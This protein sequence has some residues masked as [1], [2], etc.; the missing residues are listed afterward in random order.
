MTSSKYA[1]RVAAG[2]DP[3]RR[4]RI[5]AGGLAGVS[6]E[7]MYLLVSL[8]AVVWFYIWIRLAIR[9]G[10]IGFDFEGTLWNAGAAILDGRSPYPAPVIAEVDAGNP[11][12][13]P[14][15]LMVLV[16]PLT[17][18]PWWVGVTVWTALLGAALALALYVLDVR[19]P[20]CY[21]LALISA[22]VINGLIWGNATLLLIPLVALAWR[23]RD[24]WLRAGVLIGLAIGAK[25]FLWPLVF[26]LLGT[27]R[28][29]AAGAAATT[30]V[31]AV[32]IP[33]AVIGFDGLRSYPD[34]LHVAEDIYAVHGYSVATMLSAL[35]VETD[36]AT[37]GA[38]AVGV[39]IAA[40]AIVVGRWGRDEIS[41]SLAVLAAI[42]GSP[43]VWE[44]YYAL[45]LV[46]LAIARPRFSGLWVLLPLFYFTHRLPRPHLLS[47]D[48]E[49]GGS[50]CCKPDGVPLPSWVFNHA[51]PG[52]WPAA[53]HAAV[54]VVLVV[55]VA[56]SMPR[57]AER[58]L[59]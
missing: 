39:S 4:A 27:R 28:Y 32:F 56:W 50:A 51:P 37:R 34:L 49:P 33:W 17:V 11:A 8:A 42:L 16:A 44:Y 18:L 6:R 24:R 23:W 25:L 29:R 55:L 45:L 31:A 48:I 57:A 19:D 10:A 40:L 2:D 1:E 5:S 3:A 53:G 36:L 35:G 30:A 26:W 13:Y 12:L 41:V 43:I 22:P 54:A 14:P 7:C 58:T 46:P 20:R 21:L 59:R 9:D 15:L 38:L 52:L 47:T